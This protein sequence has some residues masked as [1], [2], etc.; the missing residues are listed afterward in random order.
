LPDKQGLVSEL[1]DLLCD[2]GVLSLAEV[3][4]SA[5]QR[6][7]ALF[8]EGAISS[9]ALDRWRAAEEAVYHDPRNPKASWRAEDLRGV[10]KSAGLADVRIE[11]EVW[12]RD[13]ML[14]RQQ[15]ASWLAVDSGSPSYADRLVAAG[16]PRADLETI[17][18]AC[19]VH[20]GD[21]VAAWQTTTAFV[22]GCR[23][24]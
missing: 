24:T 14:T 22:V 11:T 18:Q 3:V 8:P 19:L 10:F 7:S 12:R 16:L 20:L 17:R 6:L 13:Q 23:S 1:A 21:Q 4:P 9:D 5:T 15:L 2:R